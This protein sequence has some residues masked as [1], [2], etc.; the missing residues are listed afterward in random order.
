MLLVSACSTGA[1]VSQPAPG[2]YG[3]P[4]VEAPRDITR[5]ADDPCSRLLNNDQKTRLGITGEG[6]ARINAVG[7][8]ECR[9]DGD[10]TGP[11]VSLTTYTN[12]DILV[13]SYRNRMYAVF[14]PIQVAGLPAVAQQT[15]AGTVSCTVT[16]GTA[17]GQGLDATFDSFGVVGRTPC[18]GATRVAEAVVANLPPLQK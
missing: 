13:A 18:D 12:E 5:V 17:D 10:G 4:P 15:S 9:W 6:R 2:R 8:A 14:Q 11:G 3:A 7:A 1:P 16:V